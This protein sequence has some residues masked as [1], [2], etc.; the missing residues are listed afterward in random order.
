MHMSRQ[1]MFPENHN[2]GQAPQGARINRNISLTIIVHPRGP[3][4]IVSYFQ[5]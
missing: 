4:P 1:F 5:I 3:G 2:E